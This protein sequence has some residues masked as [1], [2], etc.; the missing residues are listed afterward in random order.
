MSRDSQTDAG[1]KGAMPITRAMA[2]V[3]MPECD[4]KGDWL[5]AY[6]SGMGMAASTTPDM[7]D[8]TDGD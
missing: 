3:M 7:D 4:C 2:S 8:D 1:R 5:P 6:G